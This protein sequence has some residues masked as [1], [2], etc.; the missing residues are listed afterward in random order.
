MRRITFVSLLVLVMAVVFVGAVY[1]STYNGTV[2]FTCTTWNATGTGSHVLDRDNTGLGQE[3]ITINLYDGAGT[4]LHTE[5]YTNSLGTFG[6]GASSGIYDLAAPAYNPIRFVMISPAG[7]GLPEQVDV[8]ITGTCA[9][10]PTYADANAC[11]LNVPSGSV[12]GEAPNGAQI[13][14][15]PD[16]PTNVTLNPGTYIVVGQDAS[17]TYY[18]I[19]LACQFVWVRKDTMQP[20]YQAPQNGAP[21]PTSIV[22]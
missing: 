6:G 13:Y 12:V 19:V 17:E 9:G 1:A 8:D 15:A 22:S 2:I 14:Y 16:A 20:S 7:N 5:T 21:L 18:K 10:L 4:L 11:G 3:R